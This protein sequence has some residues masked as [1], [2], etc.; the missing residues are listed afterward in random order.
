MSEENTDTSDTTYVESDNSGSERESD[1]EVVADRQM[2]ISTRT[3][4]QTV[5]LVDRS[6]A[7]RFRVTG[8]IG[9]TRRISA[10][11]KAMQGLM[12]RHLHQVEYCPILR[13]VFLRDDVADLLR[14]VEVSAAPLDPLLSPEVERESNVVISHIV[15]PQLEEAPSHPPF[16]APRQEAVRHPTV[17]QSSSVE[18]L[19]YKEANPGMAEELREHQ[20]SG[21]THLEKEAFLQRVAEREDDAERKSRQKRLKI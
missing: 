10:A 17:L 19:K 5:S 11:D 4:K 20:R 14:G 9:G 7:P 8:K 3:M 1:D 2:L 16:L 21:T 18:W 15:E 12:Q 6:H 13:R